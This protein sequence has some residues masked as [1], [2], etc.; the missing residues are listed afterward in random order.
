MYAIKFASC[1][2]H[3][4]RVWHALG[5]PCPAC[6]PELYPVRGD[7]DVGDEV[8]KT[9]FVLPVDPAPLRDAIL[10]A[11]NLLDDPLDLRVVDVIQAQ[12][13]LQNALEGF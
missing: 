2:K 10:M 11:R 13:A 7:G 8:P 1:E 3:E 4:R 9:V 5:Q 6:H 12:V